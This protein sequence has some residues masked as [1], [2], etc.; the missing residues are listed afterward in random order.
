MGIGKLFNVVSFKFTMRL[1][2]DMVVMSKTF[3]QLFDQGA[4][5]GVNMKHK[6]LM[7]RSLWQAMVDLLCGLMHHASHLFSL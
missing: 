2:N 5:L 6:R 3:R 7:K 4:L 1:K